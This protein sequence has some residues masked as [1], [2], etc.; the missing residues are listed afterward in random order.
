MKRTLLALILLQAIVLPGCQQTATTKTT[1][2]TT[3]TFAEAAEDN[4]Q[5]A[6]HSLIQNLFGDAKIVAGG[7]MIEWEVPDDGT[8]YY[9]W[10]DKLVQTK[11]VIAGELF[12]INIS[13]EEIAAAK[14]IFGIQVNEPVISYLYFKPLEY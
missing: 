10:N 12:E 14:P 6:R 9:T 4:S 11:S 13:P 3:E 1:T 7:L 2:T 8:C 5:P